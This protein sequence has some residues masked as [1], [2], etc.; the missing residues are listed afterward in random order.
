M[1]AKT[2]PEIMSINKPFEFKNVY[3]NGRKLSG[4]FFNLFFIEN[5]MDFN[6]YG[7]VASKKAGKAVKRNRMKRRLREAVKIWDKECKTGYDFVIWAKT[8]LESCE[9]SQIIEE[10]YKMLTRA[11]MC[12]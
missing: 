2:P 1:R 12:I 6:R 5:G 3:S 9:F 4:K 11:R 8:G 10:G 7:I